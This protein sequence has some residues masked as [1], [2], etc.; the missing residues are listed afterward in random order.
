MHLNAEKVLAQHMQQ[1]ARVCVCL[2]M[3]VLQVNKAESDDMDKNMTSVVKNHIVV[4]LE[5]RCLILAENTVQ[6]QKG[7]ECNRECQLA[8]C[9]AKGTVSALPFWQT[10]ALSLRRYITTSQ[11]LIDICCHMCTPLSE[12]LEHLLGQCVTHMIPHD[13]SEF[14]LQCKMRSPNVRCGDC[15][16][17]R[18]TLLEGLAQNNGI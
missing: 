3:Y 5:D 8:S 1:V 9:A 16:C 10:N 2:S 4:Q 6:D 15:T 18:T 17:C 13:P 7:C 12:I 14:A 11:Q